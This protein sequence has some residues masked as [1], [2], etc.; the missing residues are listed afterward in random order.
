LILRHTGWRGL[1]D[2]R[3]RGY[4][5]VWATPALG[6]IPVALSYRFERV[7]ALY[8]DEEMLKLV[9]RRSEYLGIANIDFRYSPPV[10]R[11]EFPP[12]SVDAVILFHLPG[13]ALSSAL[14]ADCLL[15]LRPS[16]TLYIGLQD[17]STDTASTPRT[18]ALPIRLIS[19]AL[20]FISLWLTLRR[21]AASVSAHQYSGR[22]PEYHEM[23]P[24]SV[25]AGARSSLLSLLAPLRTRTL[26]LVARKARF[27]QSLIDAVA[28]TV[29][30]ILLGR[31]S[32][33]RSL[34]VTRIIM[35]YPA[36]ITLIASDGNQEIV[37]RIPSDP[38]T[39]FR[40]MINHA[41]LQDLQGL[42]D[43]VVATLPLPLAAAETYGQVFYVETATSGRPVVRADVMDESR[44][45]ALLSEASRW[46]ASFQTQTVQRQ[47]VRAE[48]LQRLVE[49]PFGVASAYLSRELTA[50]EIRKLSDYLLHALGDEELP[51]CTAHGD[52]SVDN[53]RID[54]SGNF[55][56]VFDWDLSKKRSLPLTDLLYFLVTAESIR[57]GEDA[58]GVWRNYLL[59]KFSAAEQA[60]ID[61]YLRV[62]DIPQR[63]VFP[64]TIMTCLQ[65]VGERLWLP[66]NYRFRYIAAELATALRGSISLLDSS[67]AARV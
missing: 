36:G 12:Q 14:L 31:V 17:V 41:A 21:A 67:K 13:R 1:L 33:W 2:S 47:V 10:G 27:Q 57:R 37:I 53:V 28:Q 6:T 11:A 8:S 7:T 44:S 30:Q 66:E 60:S 64:L 56:G 43:E 49:K 51:I 9:Q 29:D 46:L 40:H 3:N 25:R 5:V 4:A 35:G 34:K 52:F 61:S 54:D 65:H 24:L 20:K 63:L 19:R 48:E 58:Q 59:Q 50:D 62:L 22:F 42:S 18:G 15:W 16:G 55:S 38:G 39:R 45:A 23:A 26:S 32:G